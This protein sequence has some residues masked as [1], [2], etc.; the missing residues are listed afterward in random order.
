MPIQQNFNYG[1]VVDPT[2][3]LQQGLS[4]LAGILTQQDKLKMADEETA[5]R[6]ARQKELD[7]R[8]TAEQAQKLAQQDVLNKRYMTEMERQ[9]LRDAATDKNRADQLAIQRANA[10]SAEQQR[11]YLRDLELGKVEGLQA[12]IAGRK[13]VPVEF[14][15]VLNKQKLAEKHAELTGQLERPSVQVGPGAVPLSKQQQYYTQAKKDIQDWLTTQ[16]GYRTEVP[17]KVES[18]RVT[19]QELNAQV[20]AATDAFVKNYKA[21]HKGQAPSTAIVTGY[22]ASAAKNAR[23]IIVTR[24]ATDKEMLK[25]IQKQQDMARKFQ[26]SK[27]LEILKTQLKTQANA[28]TDDLKKKKLINEIS[29]IDAQTRKID[30]DVNTNS[31]LGIEY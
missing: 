29:K 26:Q 22:K 31:F 12:D 2:Q 21:S 27:N 28:E 6:L 15:D 20:N 1:R 9:A 19:P 23:D 14:A 10:A 3:S 4:G 30:K 24:Q 18:Q 13:D 5:A 16:P 7:A 11:R 17:T 8:Y 25:Q